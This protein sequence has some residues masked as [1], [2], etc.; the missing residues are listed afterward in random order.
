MSHILHL[1]TQFEELSELQLERVEF[2]S[3]VEDLL[4]I[5]K[6]APKLQSF[7]Y[8]A[9]ISQRL[10]R[11]RDYENLL[12]HFQDPNAYHPYSIQVSDVYELERAEEILKEL[13]EELT[14]KL[15]NISESHN[16][17][18]YHHYVSIIYQG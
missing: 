17:L 13:E 18:Y 10:F 2:I 7:H 9:L 5:I 3:S 12:L 8:S 4:E 14:T 6:C 11:S 16:H 15:K 1:C